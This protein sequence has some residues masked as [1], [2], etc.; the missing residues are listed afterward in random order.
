[1][2]KIGVKVLTGLAGVAIM[3][4]AADIQSKVGKVIYNEK[5]KNK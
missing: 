5:I 1:M 3:I 4:A 2:S